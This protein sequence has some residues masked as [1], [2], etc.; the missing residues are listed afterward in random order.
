MAAQ[1]P[2]AQLAEEGGYMI[3]PKDFAEIWQNARY[4]GRR[5]DSFPLLRNPPPSQEK[6]VPSRGFSYPA[7]RRNRPG[8]W[9]DG[10]GLSARKVV[11]SP[12][13]VRKNIFPPIPLL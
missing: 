7:G 5:W 13:G 12:R 2:A 11:P 10:D 4:A 8:V 1:L 6:E 9:G 3:N